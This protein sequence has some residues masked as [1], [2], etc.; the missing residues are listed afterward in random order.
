MEAKVELHIP[1]LGDIGVSWARLGGSCSCWVGV[2]VAE[3]SVWLRRDS[4]VVQETGP[5]PEA[6]MEG[7]F[8]Y[9]SLRLDRD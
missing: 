8:T 6:G 3:G 1:Y 7:F 9:P 2:L 4:W 5:A